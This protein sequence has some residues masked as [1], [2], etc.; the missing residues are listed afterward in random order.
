[1]QDPTLLS[2][3]SFLV[4]RLSQIGQLKK[5]TWLGSVEPIR[6]EMHLCFWNHNSSILFIACS[7]VQPSLCGCLAFWC[8]FESGVTLWNWMRILRPAGFSLY[9]HFYLV[10]CDCN[11]SF[12]L[13]DV[14]RISQIC[15]LLCKV[16]RW[17]FPSRS[18]FEYPW[19][20]SKLACVT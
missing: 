12:F 17:K 7:L 9:K 2:S 14:S 11:W 13:N 10:L 4:W 3:F 16:P 1:M 8:F 5:I 19:R 18:C 20:Q 6:L 15:F